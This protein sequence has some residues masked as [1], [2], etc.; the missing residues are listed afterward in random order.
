MS[1]QTSKMVQ[2]LGNL[3][4]EKQEEMLTAFAQNTVH[5]LKTADVKIRQMNA[6]SAT[7]FLDN[8]KAVQNHIGGIHAAAMFLLIETATGLALGMNVSD[9]CIPLAKST[10]IDYKKMTK[11]SLTATATLTDEQIEIITSTEKGEVNIAVEIVDDEGNEPLQ[12]SMTWA[13]IPKKKG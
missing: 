1:N 12:A 4:Q 8:Q 7:V 13:W 9:N 11:S 5:F 2:N 3:P 6:N 10:Q